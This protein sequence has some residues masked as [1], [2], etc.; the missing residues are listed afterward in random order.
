MRGGVTASH[1]DTACS[2]NTGRGAR[3]AAHGAQ[4]PGAEG[5]GRRVHQELK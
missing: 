5:S 4:P 3:R 1:R 2:V